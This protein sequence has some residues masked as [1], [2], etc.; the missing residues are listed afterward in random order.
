VTTK[1]VRFCEPNCSVPRQMVTMTSMSTPTA[2]LKTLK[3]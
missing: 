3:K 2:A 1:S